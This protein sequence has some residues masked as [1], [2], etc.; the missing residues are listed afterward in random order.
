[1]DFLTQILARLFDKFK[2]DHPKQAAIVLLVLVSF[3]FFADQGTFL[4][5]FTLPAWAAEAIK[6]VSVI[7]AALSGSRTVQYLPADLRKEREN[8]YTPIGK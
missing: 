4:G 8:E 3:V 6:W 1:M 5:V 7:T 2:V